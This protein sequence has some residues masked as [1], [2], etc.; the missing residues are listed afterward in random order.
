MTK[1]S[2]SKGQSGKKNSNA[3]SLLDGIQQN[4]FKILDDLQ[5]REVKEAAEENK[6]LNNF[7][8][9]EGNMNSISA[10]FGGPS[11]FFKIPDWHTYYKKFKPIIRRVL[12]EKT[13]QQKEHKVIQEELEETIKAQLLEVYNQSKIE[14]NSNTG[15]KV[16][17]PFVDWVQDAIIQLGTQIGQ[18]SQQILMDSFMFDTKNGVIPNTS[19]LGISSKTVFWKHF[20]D[21]NSIT[22]PNPDGTGIWPNHFMP[23]VKAFLKKK[24]SPDVINHEVEE[25]LSRLHVN[26]NQYHTNNEES[27]R[28]WIITTITGLPKG[29]GITNLQKEELIA[30]LSQVITKLFPQPDD[31]FFYNS[32]QEILYRNITRNLNIK[33]YLKRMKN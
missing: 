4:L 8:K 27:I 10:E 22:K 32:L 20:I 9:A 3:N 23:L 31:T 18:S 21:P 17:R 1:K 11:P 2:A 6:A 15:K 33:C 30:E 29:L 5:T 26:L 14:T 24:D 12:E 19:N 13:A 7:I 16:L 28:A 25:V